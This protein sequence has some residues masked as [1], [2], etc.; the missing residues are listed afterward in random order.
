MKYYLYCDLNSESFDS[1]FIIMNKPE[2]VVLYILWD[3][4]LKLKVLFI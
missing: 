4:R 3:I 2:A 1:G